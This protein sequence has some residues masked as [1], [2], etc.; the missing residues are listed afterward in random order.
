MK[1]GTL[2]VLITGAGGF[3]GEKLVR[4]LL[5]A[6][7][8]KVLGQAPSRLTLFDQR[9]AETPSDS[10][11]RR[12]EGDLSD[13][14]ALGDAV[15]DADVVFHLASLPGGAASRDFPLGLQINLQAMISLLELLR[16][17]GR[18]PRVVFASTVGV[19]G[20]PMPEVID[21]NTIAQPSMSYGSHKL[22]GEVL[23]NDY[24]QRGF[25]DG[26]SLRLPG[27]VARPLQAAGML[28]AFMSDMLRLLSAGEKFVCPVAAEGKSWWMSR[29]CVVDNL[30]RAAALPVEQ[31]TAPRMWLMP[32]LHASTGE[33]VEA[34]ARLHGDQVLRNVA[35]EPNAQL[36]AQF[37][38]FPPLRCPTSLAAG[39]RNDGTLE[40]L[41]QRA[42]EA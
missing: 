35:Y 18:Q 26:R 11:V 21:E 27:I 6:D 29:P 28:S 31:V 41:V 12:I 19:Y 23:I 17:G 20:V 42:L 10:R 25:I 2:N 32:V 15:K 40:A 9:L 24:S 14:R 13:K 5:S 33:V 22:I 7:V 39:F 38:N 16:A 37:A 8:H 4:R 34:I 1:P 3:I 30:L 36:Q